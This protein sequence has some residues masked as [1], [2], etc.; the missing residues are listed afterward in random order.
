MG[1]AIMIQVP[2]QRTSF[3]PNSRV[4]IRIREEESF[5]QCQGYDIIIFEPQE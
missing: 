2:L 3:G 5:H 1:A 4:M